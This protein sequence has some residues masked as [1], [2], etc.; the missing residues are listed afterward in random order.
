MILRSLQSYALPHV[1][2]YE[3][4]NANLMSR[5]RVVVTASCSSD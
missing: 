3:K 1:S 5:D 2:R 4:N